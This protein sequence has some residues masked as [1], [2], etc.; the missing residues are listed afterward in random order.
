MFHPKSTKM[1]NSFIKRFSSLFLMLVLSLS[2]VACDSDDDLTATIN[3]NSVNNR[4]GDVRGNGGTATKTW[5]FTNTNSTAG[6]DMTIND[7]TS[8]SFNLTLMDDEGTVVL[9]QTLRAGSGTSSADGT[10]VE[11]V[12]GNWTAT[13]TLNDFD[14]TGD[15][16]FL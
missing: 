6:W 12:P 13:A 14:G 5:T 10:T 3:V 11:G 8:G 4:S 15:Y 1:K 2:F 16:S 7:S 9:D